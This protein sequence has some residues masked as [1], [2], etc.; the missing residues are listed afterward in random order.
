MWDCRFAGPD[1]GL[2]F[3]WNIHRRTTQ[4]QLGAL[5]VVA[6]GPG[7][8]VAPSCK[9]ASSGSKTHPRY[10]PASSHG[11]GLKR[12]RHLRLICDLPLIAKTALFT[13]TSDIGLESE[14]LLCYE[15]RTGGGPSRSN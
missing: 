7:R 9:F 6:P 8:S 11:C 15:I 5:G 3:R 2:F 4:S 12:N 14:S 13:P 10:F 1:D